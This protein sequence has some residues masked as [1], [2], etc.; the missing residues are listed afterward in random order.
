M[1][2]PWFGGMLSFD[3]DGG[4]EAVRIFVERLKVFTLAESLGGIE[5]LVAHPKT[6]THAY[7][8]P[9]AME[10]AGITDGLL[11]LS[12]G[13]EEQNDLVGDL[14]QAFAALERG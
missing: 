12:I 5:S 13:L 7:L 8:D 6:M 2:L 14:V 4:K 3:L 11:R 1:A 9:D 10:A